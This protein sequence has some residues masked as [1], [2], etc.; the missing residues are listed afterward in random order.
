GT[1][2]S[3]PSLLVDQTVTIAAANQFN[4]LNLGAS[5]PVIN[6][7]DFY[8]GYVVDTA[9]G[10]FPD[11]GR[12]LFPGIRSFASNNGGQTYQM[13]N[14]QAQDGQQFNAAIRAVV[15][16]RLN[17]KMSAQGL[18]DFFGHETIEM[19]EPELIWIDLQ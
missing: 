8:V 14:V 16:T 3:N 15:N 1:P 13:F 12:V 17:G 7:G 6:S 11:V 10:I 19:I 4:Q 9:N 5:G 18:M 2:P